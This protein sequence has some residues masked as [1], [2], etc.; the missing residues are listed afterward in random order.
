MYVIVR[1]TRTLL[2]LSCNGTGAVVSGRDN[3]STG[4]G[5]VPRSTYINRR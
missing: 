2:A 4:H 5:S 3:A 1:V